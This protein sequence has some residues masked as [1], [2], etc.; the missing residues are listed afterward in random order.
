MS[1]EDHP[2]DAVT[3]GDYSGSLN[4][5]LREFVLTLKYTF[6]NAIRYVGTTS[7]NIST[8]RIRQIDLTL[9]FEAV[10]ESQVSYVWKIINRVHGKYSIIFD[11]RIYSVQQLSSIPLINQYLLSRFLRDLLGENPFGDLSPDPN[12]LN[13]RCCRTIREQE[14]VII[15][16]MPRIA[17]APGQLRTIGQSVYDA[18]RAYLIFEGHPVASEEQAYSYFTEHYQRFTEAVAIHAGEM[19]P[20]SVIDIGSYLVDSLAI[21]K[22]LFYRTEN[23]SV[24]DEVLLVNTPSS[25]MPHPHDDYLSYDHNMPLG[26]ICVASYLREHGYA[27]S[28]LDSYAENL[29]VL[30]TVDRVFSGTTL[31]RVI[32]FNSSSPNIHIVHK[33]A[34]Y[35]KRIRSDIIIVCGGP[36]ASLA[37]EHTLS[38]GDIDYAVVGE[39]EIPLFNLVKSIFGA[40]SGFPAEI[41]GVF[42]RKPNGVSGQVNN[43]FLDL[44][45]MPVPDLDLLPLQR[46]FAIKKRV[47]VHTSRGCAFRCIYC[48]V[49]ECWG[50]SVRQIPA[51]A[52]RSQIT[53]LLGK[54]KP[55]EIQIVDDNFSHEEGRLIRAFCGMSIDAGW[56]IKWKCQVRA[57]Q[58][59]E[60]TIEMMSKTGC[61]EVDL[62][63]ESGNPEIQ[64]YIR[65]NLDL[66]KTSKVISSISNHGI[67]TK[68]FFMLGFPEE[69]YAQI[70]DTINYAVGLKSIGLNDVAFFPVMPFPGTEISKVT[71][72]TVFQGAVI[73]DVDV[74][75]R[76]FAGHRLRKYSA[77]PEIS[78]NANFSPETLRLLVKFA[79][80][81]FNYGVHVKDLKPEF[82][83]FVL[84]EESSRYA[85]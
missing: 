29:G 67:I 64:K 83:D 9:V 14:D 60:A 69:T 66:S 24:A 59:D 30:A 56:S 55:D 70:T 10:T 40:P 57:D 51:D 53:E 82:D 22:H 11:A 19:D 63:V 58:L 39:G 43:A 23:K 68:A 20:S 52:L 2:A 34:A 27:V 85:L 36:H 6:G 38:T 28:I 74:Y 26:L 8:T 33:I 48:S 80:Q 50:R 81:H 4:V 65:K 78:L 75:E 72:R 13:E 46:Y 7:P 21:V 1:H 61:F 71:G 37:T 76:S 49:P 3:Y 45:T 44:S 62:G 54:Y 16:A 73:D 18:I 15:T 79:Y 32:G 84:G 25:L 47:Y 17:G 31:P 42:S 12:V 41:P 77:K 5:I 35:L